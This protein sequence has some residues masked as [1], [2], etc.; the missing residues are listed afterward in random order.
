MSGWFKL[1]LQSNGYATFFYKKNG[2]NWSDRN[3]WYIEMSQS[4]TK[5]N[6]VLD[7]TSTLY[8]NDVSQNWN[9]FN[10]VSDGTGVKVYINGSSSH[11]TKRDNYVWN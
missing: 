7:N 2:G 1:P 6:L 11:A 10:V 9:Y 5:A 8:F 4:T 3:G